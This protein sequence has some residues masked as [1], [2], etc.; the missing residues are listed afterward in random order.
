MYV[1]TII[2]TY[3]HVRIEHSVNMSDFSV[4]TTA[5]PGVDGAGRG[6]E[7]VAV[8]DHARTI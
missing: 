4:P 1:S 2:A 6:G 7:S 8:S 3:F 5:G